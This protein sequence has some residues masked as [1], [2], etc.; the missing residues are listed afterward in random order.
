[1][2][3]RGIVPITL[4]LV[5][6]GCSGPSSG[7]VTLNGLFMKQAGYSEDDVTAATKEFQAANPGITV[8]LTFVPYEQLEQKITTSAEA[9]TYDVVLSDG[10]FTAKFAKSGLV[11]SVPELADADVKDIFA[12][13]IDSSVYQG[14]LYGMPW[15]NDVKYLF[16]NKAMLAKAGFKEPPKTLDEMLA[17]AKTLKAK[18]IVEY[19]IAWSWSQ[20]EAL[21][22]DYTVL[23]AD[24]GGSMFDAGGKPTLTSDANKKALSFMVSSIKDGLT[25]PKSTEFIEDDVGNVFTAGQA[26]FALNWTYMY[27]WA[28]DPAKSKV[29]NDVGIAPVPGT[30]GVASATVNGGQP[31]AITKGSKHPVEAWKYILY[32]TGRDFQKKY[33]KNSLPIWKSLY[34]DADVVANNPEVVA[35]AKVQYEYIANRPKVPYYSN[36]SSQ[37]QASLQ[38][39]L[40]GKKTPDAALAEAQTM[41]EGLAS[42]N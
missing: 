24:F 14:K 29:V 27:A 13:A 39:A 16:Y 4:A 10:P 23:T 38:Q 22:C 40:L 28:K 8:N 1:M 35:T 3:L 34:A 9:G 18:K 5:L 19:P 36:F 20:A 6:A 33:S 32:L 31:L 7:P 15:L 11:Q 42:Q 37:M 41:A 17:M 2:K 12:G 21:M 26:A 25:N 30:A